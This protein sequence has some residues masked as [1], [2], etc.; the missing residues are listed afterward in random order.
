MTPTSQICLKV[1]IVEKRKS[2]HKPVYL[3]FIFLRSPF[4]LYIYSINYNDTL[5][6]NLRNLQFTLFGSYCNTG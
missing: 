1:Y 4:S 5:I 6:E 3:F 2:Q